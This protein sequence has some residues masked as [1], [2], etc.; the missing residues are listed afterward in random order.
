MAEKSQPGTG[1][2]DKMVLD[3]ARDLDDQ[4]INLLGKELQL[5]AAEIG[6][7]KVTNKMNDTHPEGTIKMLHSWR[8]SKT[9]TQQIP[10]LTKALNAAGLSRLAAEY[11]YVKQGISLIS[12]SAF[13]WKV[14]ICLTSLKNSHLQR[15]SRI[16]QIKYNIKAMSIDV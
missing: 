3:L 5:S 8:D 6:R 2:T 12:Y 7:I 9:S 16:L 13:D 1:L 4:K 15:N 11:L 10:E 14:Y